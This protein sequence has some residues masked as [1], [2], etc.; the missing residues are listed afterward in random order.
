MS[1]MLANSRCSALQS[2]HCQPDSRKRALAVVVGANRFD[3]PSAC[4]FRFILS[5]E[6]LL[7][8]KIF[9]HDSALVK[10]IHLNKMESAADERL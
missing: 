8:D 7:V 1:A 9:L 3:D 4:F 10:V 2:S 5:L 6:L